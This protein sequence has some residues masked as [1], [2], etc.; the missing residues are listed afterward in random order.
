LKSASSQ[1]GGKKSALKRKSMQVDAANQTES[2]KK[3][4]KGTKTM[5]STIK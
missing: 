2:S 3:K 5:N 4:I 1:K